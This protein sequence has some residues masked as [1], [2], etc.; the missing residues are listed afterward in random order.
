MAES[1]PKKARAPKVTV[2]SS[3]PQKPAQK[4]ADKPA[5]KAPKPQAQPTPAPKPK[6][7]APAVRVSAEPKPQPKPQPAPQPTPQPQPQAAPAA[8]VA[9]EQPAPRPVAEPVPQPTWEEPEPQAAAPSRQ[10]V[11]ETLAEARSNVAGA[12]TKLD[13]KHPHAVYFGLL[14]LLLALLIFWIGFFPTLLIVLLVVAGVALGQLYDGDPKIINALKRGIALIA[15][16][17]N[18]EV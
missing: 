16:R 2:V 12:L 15:P 10:T 4:S 5:A 17:N 6:A 7:K 1:T 11:G 9:P 14:G 8:G 18:D 13:P 3:A